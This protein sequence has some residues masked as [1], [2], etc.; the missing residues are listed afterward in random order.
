M[1]SLP[2]LDYLKE[3]KEDSFNLAQSII[4]MDILKNKNNINNNDNIT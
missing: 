1:Y 2:N 4:S 3:Q